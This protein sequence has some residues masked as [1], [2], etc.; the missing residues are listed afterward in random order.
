MYLDSSTPNMKLIKP[1]ANFSRRTSYKKS[2][3]AVKFFFKAWLPDG[4]SQ[5]FR[6]YVFG[7]SGFWIWTMAPLR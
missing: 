1:S 3:K 5:I 4:F 2:E 7:S 6:S